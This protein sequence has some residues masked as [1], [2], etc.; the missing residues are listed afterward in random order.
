VHVGHPAVDVGHKRVTMGGM[1]TV[2]CAWPSSCYAEVRPSFVYQG[3]QFHD[4]GLGVVAVTILSN[5]ARRQF[6]L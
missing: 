5:T 6:G 2:E 4:F 3:N 1:L